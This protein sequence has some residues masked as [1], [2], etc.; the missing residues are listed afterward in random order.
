MTREKVLQEKLEGIKV[1]IEGLENQYAGTIRD[2]EAAESRLKTAKESLIDLK[3]LS[4]K[5]RADRQEAFAKGKPVGLFKKI[6]KETQGE[7]EEREDEII[8][9]DRLKEELKIRE[10]EQH[11]AILEAYREIPKTRLLYCA[12]RYNELAALMAPVIQEIW[13]LKYQLEEINGKDITVFCPAGWGG[14]ALIRLPR[15]F[16]QG[17]QVSK[18]KPRLFF[19]WRSFDEEWIRQTRGKASTGSREHAYAGIAD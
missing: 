11:K 19:D 3:G 5:A 2:V 14:T 8:G 17:E 6:L 10:A 18:D 7:I 4:E 1:R 15:I 13:D 16:T 9:L 12:E